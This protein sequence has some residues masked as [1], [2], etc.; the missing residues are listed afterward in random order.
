MAIASLR[1]PISPL[2]KPDISWLDGLASVGGDVMGELGA[3]K[4][5]GGL[6]DRIAGQTPQSPQG[7]F[8]SR[9]T[10]GGQQEVAAT[11]PSASA[12]RSGRIDPAIREG[13][14]RTASAL[15]ISPADLATAISYETGGTFDPTKKGPRTK[16]GQH[17]GLIQFG[18]PQARDFGVD[19]N[20]PIGSQLGENGAVEKYLRNAGVKPGMG[21]LDVYS[22][23]NA[24]GV[25]LYDR[26]DEAAGG[27][28]GTVRDKVEKQMAG[29]RARALALFG[30]APASSGAQA[31]EMVSPSGGSLADEVAAFEQTPEYSA[32]FPGQQPGFD[33][34]RFGN[35]SVPATGYEQAARALETTNALGS[36]YLDEAIADSR[37]QIQNSAP[38]GRRRLPNEVA[39]A[40]GSIMA[41]GVTPVERGGIDPSI[42]QY[43]LRDPNLREMGVK[44]WAANVQGQKAGE[45][46]QFVNLPDGTL[47]RANQ[48]TGQ[49]ERV[50]NF[51][52]P[53]EPKS[54]INLGDGRLF[55]PN[56]REVID[57]TGG[58][59]KA[60]NIV[61]LFDEQTGQPY[62][63]R[64]NDETQQFDRVGGVKAP[65]GMQINTNPDGTVS[66]TQGAVNGTP[67]LTEQQSKD[68]VYYKR[69]A[70]ALETL[71]NFGNE[72][73]GIGGALADRIPGG[74]FMKS[75]EYQRA[76]QA[77]LEFLQAI[78]RKDTG[79][80]ITPQET[81]EYGKVYLPRPGDSPALLLQKKAARA[82][83]LEAI[84]SGLGPAEI[85]AGERPNGQKQGR[86]TSTGVQWSIEE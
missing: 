74:N 68:L 10:G 57:A 46:W 27:A 55:D 1:V 60:P 41:A 16:W 37:R 53:P 49:I 4:S 45:P 25:G 22:A 76:Q 73:T 14:V 32:Q 79:A 80:A 81:E 3:R 24:G 69:G 82:R 71:D 36:G 19:W 48:Q 39:D 9:L 5:F 77:G 65:S 83:A 61:E 15:G 75:A 85:L 12:G 64:W 42:I 34:G 78:L 7:G 72:L 8:L 13:I 26:S 67:K 29:H 11:S 58:R 23:I 52:K 47:A 21:L 30:D 17:R 31:I 62:K 28:P 70:G 20:D 40:S 51:A 6:A 35:T 43:M 38:D 33:S 2:P 18:E 54:L 50:G 63:A 59:Q 66:V 84:R 86:K 56:N 44:L